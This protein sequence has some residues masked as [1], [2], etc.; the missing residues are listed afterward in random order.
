[1]GKTSRY[2]DDMNSDTSTTEKAKAFFAL[3]QELINLST[4]TQR[5]VIATAISVMCEQ[6]DAKDQERAEREAAE[7]TLDDYLR[8]QSARQGW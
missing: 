8:L 4:P 7:F 2:N 3:A 1:M 6:A 5:F